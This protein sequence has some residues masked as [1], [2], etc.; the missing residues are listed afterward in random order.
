MIED[1]R[2]SACM[3]L[4]NS[5]ACVGE[6]LRCLARSRE[7]VELYVVDNRPS[8][9]DAGFL[10]VEFP[11]A[12]YYPQKRNI[13][14][15]RGNN[16]V[17]PHLHS[18]YHLLLNPDVSF[19]PELIHSMC[20]YLDHH[21]DVVILSPKVLNQDGS[22]QF[23]PR[24]RP[25][26]RYLLG[27]RLEKHG[28]IFERWRREYTMADESVTKPI[29]VEFATGCFLM[30]RTHAFRKIRGFDPR[31]FL[32]QEDSDLALK[33]LQ[34]GRVVYHPDM[35]ITHAWRRDSARRLRLTFRHMW[36]TAQFFWKWG[37]RW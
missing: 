34:L 23:L 28:R 24:R 13:G 19:D 32:Y 18:R 27:G 36:S 33:A 29:D 22:E 37:L 11:S 10:R 31:F 20:D 25:T 17:L 9:P 21:S 15:G 8:S 35:C 1:P 5:G 6:A 30:I 16:V 12:H 26:V 3:V 14:F 2:V 4:Y 7:K